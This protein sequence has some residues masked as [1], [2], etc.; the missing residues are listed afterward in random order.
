[1]ADSQNIIGKK[2]KAV[3]SKHG[4]TQAM[5]A[6][7]CGALGWDVSENTITK[8]ERGFRCVTDKEAVFFA[9]ALRINIQDLF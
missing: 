5:L 2:L 1:M 3:R 9:K 4:L 8:I 7:K 6:A